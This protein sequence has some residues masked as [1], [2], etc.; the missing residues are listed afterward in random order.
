MNKSNGIYNT[1]QREF[2]ASHTPSGLKRKKPQYITIFN[3]LNF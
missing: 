3:N 2:W 1:V